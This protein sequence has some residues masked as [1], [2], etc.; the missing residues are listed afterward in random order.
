MA[1]IQSGNVQEVLSVDPDVPEVGGLSHDSRW[2]Y[3]S[4]VTIAAD[5]WML[6]LNEEPK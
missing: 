3:F 2:I 4:K 1:D 5:I 6:T